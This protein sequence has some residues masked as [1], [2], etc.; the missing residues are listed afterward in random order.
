M[1]IRHWRKNIDM[2]KKKIIIDNKGNLKGDPEALLIIY[3]DQKKLGIK[4]K[5]IPLCG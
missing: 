2:H 3:N 4:M 5:D 1:I